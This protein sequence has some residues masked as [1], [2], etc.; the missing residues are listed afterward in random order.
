M[1]VS[2]PFPLS[3]QRRS[4]RSPL[5]KFRL[6]CHIG[7]REES[8]S[9]FAR[10]LKVS[11]PKDLENTT[12][13]KKSHHSENYLCIWERA[14]QLRCLLGH[15]VTQIVVFKSRVMQRTYQNCLFS[16]R[17]SL[18]VA[19]AEKVPYADEFQTA[20]LN[21]CPEILQTALYICSTSCSRHTT[22]HEFF[23]SQ[24]PTSAC[25]ISLSHTGSSSSTTVDMKPI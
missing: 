1:L 13:L 17:Y 25:I 16:V 23:I 3:R 12:N 14:G 18:L 10:V 20:S 7:S 6:R 21:D 15:P 4:P 22:L 24:E 11:N 9:T 5:F 8:A 2:T 19:N